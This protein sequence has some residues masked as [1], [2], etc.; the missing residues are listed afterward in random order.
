MAAYI[1]VK[2]HVVQEYMDEPFFP[3]EIGAR[4]YNLIVKIGQDFVKRKEPVPESRD[5]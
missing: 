5:L 1:A 4:T 2:I 3:L